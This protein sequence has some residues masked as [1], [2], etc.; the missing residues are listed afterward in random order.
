VT[1][2]DFNVPDT[3]L[4]RCAKAAWARASRSLPA[5]SLTLLIFPPG[6]PSIVAA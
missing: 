1:V 6:Q 5:R 4:K 2:R 3:H